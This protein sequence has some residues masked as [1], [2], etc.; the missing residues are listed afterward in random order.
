MEKLPNKIYFKIG[1]VSR[2]TELPASLLRFW[3]SE[4]KGI[5]PKRTPSGQRLYK[6]KDVA[7]I[8]KIKHLLYDRK[9]TIQGAK[10][11]LK[12]GG[13]NQEDSLYQVLCEIQD[14]LTKI[15]SILS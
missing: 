8:I 11:H 9:F 7:L 6:K 1:E 2:L 12:D 14:E 13:K 10:K 5:N 3:E 15:R 4:F